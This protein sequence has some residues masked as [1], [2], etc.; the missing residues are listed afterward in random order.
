MGSAMAITGAKTWGLTFVTMAFAAFL[1]VDGLRHLIGGA[2]GERL[3]RP[4][5][6][7]LHDKAAE[8]H[9]AQGQEASASRLSAQ[10]HRARH[11]STGSTGS[12]GSTGT[13][14]RLRPYH[15]SPRHVID[16]L[17]PGTRTR[18]MRTSTDL[19]SQPDTFVCQVD[20]QPEQSCNTPV[21]PLTRTG[22]RSSTTA[23]RRGITPSRS[24]RSRMASVT[25]T[26]PLG[27]STSLVRHRPLRPSTPSPPASAAQARQ[28][29]RDQLPRDLLGQLQLRTAVTLTE[30]PSTGNTF[31]GW[32][33]PARE[34]PR[35]ARL[36]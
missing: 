6:Q 11:G 8:G 17:G 33:G 5:Q 15:L 35:A 14:R 18:S 29:L 12:G 24:R 23:S 34:P 20:V 30:S 2:D 22:T 32:G 26:R 27:C 1:L 31:S 9:Q 19:A 4:W 10:R 7:R 3:G 36:R 28:R 13:T 25:R 21:G 16:E